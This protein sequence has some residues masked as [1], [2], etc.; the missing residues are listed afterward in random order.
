[1]R[2][3]HQIKS[4]LIKLNLLKK[5]KNRVL[6]QRNESIQSLKLKSRL[7]KNINLRKFKYLKIFVL[8]IETLVDSIIDHWIYYLI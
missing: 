8:Y 3:K 7:I 1:M 5:L 2:K 6:N 4:K